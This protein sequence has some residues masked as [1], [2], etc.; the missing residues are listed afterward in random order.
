MEVGCRNKR[1]NEKTTGISMED[2]VLAIFCKSEK[3]VQNLFAACMGKL[4][5]QCRHF[6]V[7]T[8]VCC[9]FHDST[10]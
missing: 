8:P 3:Q 9:L 2:R 7:T 6:P 4:P 1:I 10:A 5:C